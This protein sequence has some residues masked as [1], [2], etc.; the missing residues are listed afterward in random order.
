MSN[1]EMN[2]MNYR[3]RRY[4]KGHIG[5]FDFADLRDRNICFMRLTVYI[6]L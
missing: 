1:I 5:L 4:V 6:S 3:C 2:K